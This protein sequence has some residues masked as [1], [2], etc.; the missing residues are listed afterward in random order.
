[1]SSFRDIRG[2]GHLSPGCQHESR[3]DVEVRDEAECE[4]ARDGVDGVVVGMGG[5]RTH[6][7]KCQR[8]FV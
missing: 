4:G 8:D 1:M 7:R 2:Q 3:G 5:D 6:G